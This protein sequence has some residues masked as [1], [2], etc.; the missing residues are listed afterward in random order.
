MPKDNIIPFPTKEEREGFWGV[1][2]LEINNV[3]EAQQELNEIY[4]KLVD[5]II[6]ANN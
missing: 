4:R 6:I 3:E 1:S 5:N 2:Q